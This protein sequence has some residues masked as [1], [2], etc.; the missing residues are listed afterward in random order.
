M[1]WKPSYI[2][3]DE[4]AVYLDGEGAEYD[5]AMLPL[6]AA[7]ASR[8]VDQYAGRQFGSSG[9]VQVR[10][11]EAVSQR[12]TG[13]VLAYIDDL[14]SSVG[15]TVTDAADE[16]ITADYYRLG[17]RN[18][19]LNG[20]VYTTICVG[21]PGPITLSSDKWGW[22]VVPDSVKVAT[23]IQAARLAFRQASP[24]GIAGSP[25]A[26]SEQRLLATLD[27]DLKTSVRPYCR[28]W[29]AA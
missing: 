1:A 3:E 9:T 17:D 14:Y 29:Y 26:G 8:A 15:L 12:A 16:P 24:H 6:W 21:R 18:A 28:K 25:D 4:L 22:P 11:Y 23:F 20:Q 5:S 7:T 19:I 10:E 27:P 13:A 2:T